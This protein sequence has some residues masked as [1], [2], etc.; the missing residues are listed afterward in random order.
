MKSAMDVPRNPGRTRGIQGSWPGA[1]WGSRPRSAKQPI[2]LSFS[3]HPFSPDSLGILV[4]AAEPF[5][6][7][8]SL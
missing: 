8:F 7:D 1:G 4:S 5:R 6:A 2:D 3:S